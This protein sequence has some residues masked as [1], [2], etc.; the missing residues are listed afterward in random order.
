MAKRTTPTKRTNPKKAPRQAAEAFQLVI[1]ESPAKAKT[2]EKYLG[3]GFVVRASVGHI[4]DLPAKAPKGVKQPVPG[5][6]LDTFEPTYAV[7]EGKSAT[8]SELKKLAAAS[9]DVWFATDLDREGEAIAWHLAVLLG[10]DPSKAK[11]V[12]FDAV[13][14]ADVQDAFKHPHP[15]NME[16]VNAQQARRILDRIVGY[17][18]S[19]VLWRKVAG[20]LS[21]G[22]VQTP[23]ARLIVD[24]EREIAAFTPDESWEIHSTLTFDLAK[25]IVLAKEWAAFCGQRDERGRGPLVRDLMAWLA[26]RASLECEL[27]EVGG[28]PFKVETDAASTADLTLSVTEALTAAGLESVTFARTTDTTGR[29]RAVNRVAI[30]GTL[31]PKARYSVSSIDTTRTRSK[32]YPPFITS[33][34]Q[35]AAAGRL[36]FATDR[37]MRTAQQLYEGIDVP[38]EGR[39]GLITY[40]RTDSTHLSTEAINR[41]RGFIKSEYG[42]RYLPDSPRRYA[43]SNKGAQEAH[44]AI[45]PTDPARTPESIK[46]AL[47]EEQLRLYTLIWRGFVACQMVDAEWDSTAIRFLRSDRETG[48]VM[49]T[50]GRVLFFDGCYRAAGVPQSDSEQTLPK[51]KVGAEAAPF[52]LEA[53]QKFS[54]PPPRFTE[55]TLVKALEAAGIGRPSTYA[56]IVRTIQDREYVEQVDRRFYATD[57]G[58]A[59]VDFLVQAFATNFVELDYTRRIEEELDEVAQGEKE[60]KAILKTTHDFLRPLIELSAKLPHVKSVLDPAKYACP[61]CGSRTEY[62]LGKHGRFLS[63]SAY[64]A[65]KFANPVDREG[66][67]L[68][69]AELDLLSPKG[70]PMIKRHGRFGE[71]LVED[72][73]APAPAPKKDT[74]DKTDKTGKKSKKAKKGKAKEPLVRGFIL[75]IDKKG[76]IKFPAPA[77]LVT[78]IPCTRCGSPMNLR[79]GKRGPWLGCSGFPKCK[80]REA[81]GKLA[82]PMQESLTKALANQLKGH[83]PIVVTRRDG[84]PVADG[85]PVEDLIMPGG[86]ATLPIH[87]DAVS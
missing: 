28:K 75:N 19:P 86:I 4:R 37:T 87:P 10:I 24:R 23:A 38:G 56:S 49:K 40:M 22:R 27:V 15:I 16:R 43:S 83:T 41:V 77:P 30:T 17:L 62:R 84:T 63:C 12:T 31:D 3:E 73:P 79:E 45:R 42:D 60:W 34:L 32:P 50:T 5:V 61:R 47:T 82:E 14:K 68:V 71:F 46:R 57:L 70:I 1:V 53:E 54:S 35:Q 78:E 51:T 76:N 80:G 6:D 20:G 48:A 69:P 72:V 8:V 11:R 26:E 85:T 66:T 74:K 29:G 81:F 21:A 58:M 25:S 36:G 18:I 33:T 52:S 55:A 39:V 9:N 65:C 64:P 44:E 2:I 59:V 13:T 67:P 7:Q